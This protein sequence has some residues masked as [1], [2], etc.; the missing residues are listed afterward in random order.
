MPLAL[1]PR[2]RVWLMLVMLVT[3]SALNG[4]ALAETPAPTDAH[5]AAFPG[6]DW[7]RGLRPHWNNDALEELF[8]YAE[9]ERSTGIVIVHDGE[10]IEERYWPAPAGKRFQRMLAET[11]ADGRTLEDV[12]SVQ[13]SVV[14]FL[15]GHAMDQGLVALDTSIVDYIGSGWSRAA[16]AEE[17]T[18]TLRHLLS[19]TSGLTPRLKREAPAGEKWRYN[20]RVYSVLVSVLEAV[21]SK[22]IN[23]LT[24]LWLTD[25]L[26]MSESNWRQRRWL[27]GAVDANTQGFISSARDL[28]RF[29]LLMVREGQWRNQQTITQPDH[30]DALVRPS[31]ALNPAYGYLWWLNGYPFTSPGGSRLPSLIPAAPS[32]LYAAQGALGRK[33]YVVPSLKLVVVRLGDQPAADFNQQFWQ[34]LIAVLPEGAICEH[35]LPPLADAQTDAQAATSRRPFIS[36]REHIIDDPS[37]GVADL[38]GS[39]GLAMADLDGDGFEDIVSVHE[40]DTVYDGKPVGHVRIAWGSADPD[41]WELTTLASGVQAAAAEDVSIADVN[42]DGHPDVLVACELAHLIYF[43]NPGSQNSR[44]APR[45][46]SWPSTIPEIT[47]N[48]GS[49]IRAFLADLD[50]D[51]RPEVS[52]ANKGAQNPGEIENPP[53]TAF[54]IYHIP[55]NPLDGEAWTEQILGR[56][57]VPINA[58]PVDLDGDGDLDI[59]AGSRRERR[60]LWFENLGDF[61]F[62]EHRIE[63]AGAPDDLSITGFNMDYADLTGDGRTDIVSTAWPGALV[64]LEQPESATE[65]W[66]F[67]HIGA[68]KPDQLVSVRLVDL[69]DDGDLDAFSG[70]YSR[71]PRDADGPLITVN[72]PIGRIVWF[73]NDNGAWRAHQISRRKRGMYDKWLFRDL[74]GDGDLDALGTRGNSEPYDGVFWLEQRRTVEPQAVFDQARVIDSQQM[75]PPE[76]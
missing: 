35:C 9:A 4:A 18:I 56:A 70:A 58:E 15:I 62:R 32:D 65:P 2:R 25:P 50:G 31:Q 40:S 53:E 41:V 24:R 28:A 39:D 19:M 38:S 34:K 51:G 75:G 14:G 68:A 26:E 66:L 11:T 3:G 23:T 48:R 64:L 5:I 8:D 29:G 55:D 72:D 76:L 69:D 20:T 49:Y 54:S 30:L 1:I 44:R 60:V 37:L 57:Q 63:I 6:Q 17:A 22:D 59:V 46:S 27:T 10:L 47:R 16:K 52:A 45:T 61:N 73:E 71:G 67:H 36:W 7:T 42:G 74:D 13:K 21:T 12:A 33:L 43:Q